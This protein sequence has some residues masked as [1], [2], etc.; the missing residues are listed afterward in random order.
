MRYVLRFVF[1]RGPVGEIECDGASD[2][3]EQAR[4]ESGGKAERLDV[5]VVEEGQQ[6]R[7]EQGQGKAQHVTLEVD[8]FAWF[9]FHAGCFN[10]RSSRYRPDLVRALWL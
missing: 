7:C 4:A 10:L 3:D 9:T 5:A 1:C 8:R 6:N 2:G